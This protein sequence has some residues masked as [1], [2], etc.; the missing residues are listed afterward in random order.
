METGAPGG[1]PPVLLRGA[2]RVVWGNL[3]GI[4][5]SGSECVI[6]VLAGRRSHDVAVG[7]VQCLQPSGAGRVEL[8]LPPTSVLVHFVRGGGGVKYAAA[9]FGVVQC[10]QPSGTGRVELGLPPTSDLVHGGVRVC[11]AFVGASVAVGAV[12]CLQPSGAGRVELGL[13]PTSD[14]VHCDAQAVGCRLSRPGS[15]RSRR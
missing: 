3:R 13:P 11:G 7:V 14:L 1:K 8:G 12:Q 9:A 5:T 2:V 10:L 6:Q 4:C 15:S